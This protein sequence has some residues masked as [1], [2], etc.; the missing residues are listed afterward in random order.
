M[1]TLTYTRITA[2]MIELSEVFAEKHDSEITEFIKVSSSTMNT[3][4]AR[5]YILFTGSRS[6]VTFDFDFLTTNC[7]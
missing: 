5:L 3:L 6:K 1:P 4:K 7:I 2:D